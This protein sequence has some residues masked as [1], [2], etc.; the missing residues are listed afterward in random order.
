MKFYVFKYFLISCGR[1]QGS[2]LP[3][4]WVSWLS[5]DLDSGEGQIMTLTTVYVD[6]NQSKATESFVPD[7][8]EQV[9][10]DSPGGSAVDLG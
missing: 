2:E 9:L 8:S 5:V 3:E 6:L 4:L 7:S 10:I 1:R